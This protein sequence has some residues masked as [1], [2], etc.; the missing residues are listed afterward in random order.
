MKGGRGVFSTS[1]TV[2]PS[3]YRRDASMPCAP[4]RHRW[5]S[6]DDKTAM[7]P[8]RTRSHTVGSQR[9]VPEVGIYLCFDS[10]S[11]RMGRGTTLVTGS[12]VSA[13]VSSVTTLAY[14]ACY[15]ALRGLRP[16]RALRLHFFA[17]VGYIQA[18]KINLHA[19][20]SKRHRLRSICHCHE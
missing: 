4:P 7:Q 16:S 15:H 8:T 9:R 2:V 1:Q 3:G 6:D 18:P 13:C 5:T 11:T 10:S 20:Q 14:F 12:R 19:S 17:H